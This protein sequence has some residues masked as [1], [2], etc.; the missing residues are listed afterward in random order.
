[1]SRELG[2]N[3]YQELAMRTCMPTCDNVSYMLLNL[4]GEVGELSSKIAKDI[5][6]GNIV[7]GDIR[8]DLTPLMPYDEW[9]KRHEEYALELGDILWQL[10][11]LAKV[12]GLTLD[13]IAQWNLIKL[14]SRAKRGKIDGNGDHR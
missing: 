10:A 4:I 14:A 1:M 9:E 13:G 2:L 3:E 8:N 5:R 11:G 6:K 12:L 7:I